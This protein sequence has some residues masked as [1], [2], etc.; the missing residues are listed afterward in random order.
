MA[1]KWH[2]LWDTFRYIQWLTALL[3]HYKQHWFKKNGSGLV[4]H[5]KST[6]RGSTFSFLPKI[7]SVNHQTNRLYCDRLPYELLIWSYL[8]IIFK[9]LIRVGHPESSSDFENSWIVCLLHILLHSQSSQFLIEIHHIIEVKRVCK[10]HF[11]S[12]L[13]MQSCYVTAKHWKYQHWKLVSLWND[14][15]LWTGSWRQER[16]YICVHTDISSVQQM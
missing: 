3:L 15:L 5:L 2:Y 14:Y 12:T 10:H 9:L 7:L 4:R 13:N 1:K 8:M 6:H 16:T 11:M